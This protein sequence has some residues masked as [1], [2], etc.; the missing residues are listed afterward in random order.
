LF[1]PPGESIALVGLNGAGKTTLVKLL[2]ACTTDRRRDPAGRR[3]LR[4]YDL[5]SLHQRFGVIFQDYARYQ[6]SVR[7]K[8]RIGQI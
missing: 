1:I 6:F 4:E 7:E 2:T 5:G 3:D 8:H